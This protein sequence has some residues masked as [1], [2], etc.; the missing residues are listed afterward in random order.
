MP[1]SI[2]RNTVEK[3]AI[4]TDDVGDF[5]LG[6]AYCLVGRTLSTMLMT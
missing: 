1:I 3:M 6:T 5:T 2:D 4:W